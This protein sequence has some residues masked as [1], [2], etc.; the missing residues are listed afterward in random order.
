MRRKLSPACL[1]ILAAA[2][3]VTVAVVDTHTDHHDP[4][5]AMLGVARVA[6]IVAVFGL[7]GQRI[8][9]AVERIG[10][11]IK[12][13]LRDAIGEAARSVIAGSKVERALSEV[14]ALDEEPDDAPTAKVAQLP[15]QRH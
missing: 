13:A 11:D 15:I 1:A 12:A 5:E 6:V 10:E 3:L 7:V 2:A 8:V 9:R 4:L 14:S